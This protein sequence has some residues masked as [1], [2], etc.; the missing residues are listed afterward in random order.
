[1]LL[2]HLKSHLGGYTQLY[3]YSVA[4]VYVSFLCQ[5]HSVLITAALQYVLR[6]GSMMPPTLFFLLKIVLAIQ[7][8]VGTIKICS[9]LGLPAKY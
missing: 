3:F 4:L 8:I 2:V 6:S 1:M 5:Y 9:V 7:G